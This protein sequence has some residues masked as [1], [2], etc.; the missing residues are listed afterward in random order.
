[1][2]LAL[3]HTFVLHFAPMGKRYAANDG[4]IVALRV[5]LGWS[6]RRLAKA[7]GVDPSLIAQFETG[8]CGLSDRVV[9]D[10]AAE[11]GVPVEAIA[12]VDVD[13]DVDEAS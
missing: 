13:A 10:I 12:F 9:K 5:R 1:M 4:A 7:I 2:A 8:R 11:F 3:P 6:Q